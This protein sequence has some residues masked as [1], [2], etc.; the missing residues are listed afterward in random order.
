MKRSIFLTITAVGILVVVGVIGG[1][2]EAHPQYSFQK[3]D[4]FP[5]PAGPFYNGCRTCHGD[6]N[7]VNT[8]MS[9]SMWPSNL[10]GSH[11]DFMIGDGDCSTCHNS[12]PRFPVELSVSDG[13][14][15]LAPISCVGCHG[16]EADGT[17]SPDD[18][19]AGYGA[20]LRRHHWNANVDIDLDPDPVGEFIVNT[21]LCATCH[22]DADPAN[23]MTPVGEDVKPP[24]YADPDGGGSAIAHAV[25]PSDPCADPLNADLP[26]EETVGDMLALDN[27]GDLS[28]DTAD[29]DCMTVAAAPGETSSDPLVMVLATASDATTI[30]LSYGPACGAM[31]NTI[32]FGPLSAVS[33]HGY[34]GET[35]GILNSGLVT[36]DFAAAGAPE[37]FFFLIAANDGTFEGSYGI[38]DGTERPNHWANVLCPL[39][40]DLPNRCD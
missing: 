7:A 12:G 26:E 3:N 36:W 13:G 28:Y 14:T 20:G 17:P 27:D 25:M 40:Q 15:G 34:N 24:Y 35:C 2:V 5:P 16:R 18:G 10:M 6:F 29:S 8:E 31:D 33:T 37:S 38:G 30:S 4:N 1:N 21:R 39:P 19:A 9:G 22:F 11:T 32:V 23:G